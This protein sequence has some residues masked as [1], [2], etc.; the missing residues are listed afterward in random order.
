MVKEIAGYIVAPMWHEFIEK[1]LAKVPN[2][3]FKEPPQ[4]PSDLSPALRGQAFVQGPDG[5]SSAHSLLYWTNKD[6]PRSGPPMNPASDPQFRYWEAPIQAWLA[7]GGGIAPR[8]Q[9]QSEADILEQIDNLIDEAA[10]LQ[11][12]QRPDIGGQ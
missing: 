8:P 3:V 11:R 5:S 9:E 7:S 4:T 12:K 1:A 2:E 6:N 10:D